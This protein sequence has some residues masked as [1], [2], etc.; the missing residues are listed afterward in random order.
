MWNRS[1]VAQTVDTHT[2]TLKK[3]ELALQG[4][5]AYAC[6]SSTSERVKKK[7]KTERGKASARAGF[8][9]GSLS[10][11]LSARHGHELLGLRELSPVSAMAQENGESARD[12]W[13]KQ[14]D[15]IKEMFDFKEVLGT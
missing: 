6:W 15:D 10:L 13:K 11:S 9:R 5:H 8:L 2:H 3:R 14:V 4:V 1:R 12:S 7:K